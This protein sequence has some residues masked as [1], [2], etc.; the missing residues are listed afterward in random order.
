MTASLVP[1]KMYGHLQNASFVTC[2]GVLFINKFSDEPI[3]EDIYGNKLYYEELT[4]KRILDA[5]GARLLQA[6]FV[7]NEPLSDKMFAFL[8][9]K[10][11]VAYVSPVRK[12]TNSN[13]QFYTVVFELPER[14]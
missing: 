14:K 2:C 9:N 8:S 10:W 1:E 7:K 11:Q 4:D 6:G 3:K 13:K 5:H 12:N